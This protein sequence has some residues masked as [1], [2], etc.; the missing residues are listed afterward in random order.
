VLA[1]I[2]GLA[3]VNG[4]YFPTS[5]GWSALAFSWVAAMSLLL[6]RVLVPSRLEWATLAALLGL[7][8]WIALSTLWSADVTQTVLEVE[9]VLV[10]LTAIFAL[11]LIASRRSVPQLIGGLLVAI[12]L[13]S[14][15]AL[16]TRLVPERLGSF[17]Y[18]AGNRLARPLGYWNALGIF[19]AM[20]GLLALEIA[21]RARVVAARALAASALPILLPTL[22]FTFGRGPWVAL[23]AGLLAAL[24]LDTRRL[25]LI[26][27]LLV[28]APA[29]FVAVWLASRSGALTSAAPRLADASREGHRLAA[30]ILGLAVAA[31][32]SALVLARFEGRLAALSQA[33]LIYGA[34]IGVAALAGA[35]AIFAA[36]GSPWAIA[37]RGYEAFKA[38]PVRLEQ[39]QSLNKRLLNFS[40][41]GRVDMWSIAWKEAR[42]HPWVGSGA[43]T[44]EQYWLRYRPSPQKVRDA[45]GLY[46]ETLAE[47]GPPGLALLTIVLALPLVAAVRA[48]RRPLVV[49]A[50]GAYVAYVVHAG[51]DWDWEMTAVTLT[52]LFCGAAILVSARDEE[53]VGSMS[54]NVRA[55]ALAVPV[56]AGV[57]ALTGLISNSALSASANATQGQHW[58][59]AESQARK[60]IRWAPWSSEGWQLLGEAQLQQAKLRQARESFHHAIAKDPRDWTLWLDLALSTKGRSRRRAAITA[61]QLNPMSPEIA[62]IRNAVGL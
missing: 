53:R 16:A 49:G 32:L 39:G 36:Y 15:Y 6:R 37:K 46:I 59:R 7:I 42:Q 34:A 58:Q 28:L 31:G 44:Y 50:F 17:D 13:I 30:A 10:Y 1:A 20:G 62:Q 19:T 35:I 54:R 26:S 56:V 29:T 18:L 23:G 22:Y 41:N 52:G 55:G 14:A 12:T 2:A 4:A 8:A 60:A 24:A 61:I 51:I 3:A 27:T 11:L 25:Q 33:R 40:G 21:A 5:W 47:L 57:L 45:H 9:R 48:R 38:P 43:G